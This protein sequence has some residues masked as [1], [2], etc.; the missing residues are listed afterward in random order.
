MKTLSAWLLA[1]PL[2]IL[3]VRADAL[4]AIGGITT[5]ASLPSASASTNLVYEI[6]DFTI[7][8]FVVSDGTT[9]E[10]LN[11]E[12]ELYS[13]GAAATTVT[14]TVTETNIKALLIPA[15]LTSANDSV[16]VETAWTY[17][18][19]N[20]TKTFVIR[21]SASS[22]DVSGGTAF[23]AS[24]SGSTGGSAQINTIIR[25]TNSVSAQYGY[26]N[27]TSTSYGASGSTAST[28]AI[29]TASAWY[30]NINTI[31]AG[32]GDTNILKG[33]KVTWRRGGASG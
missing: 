12:T 10:P 24:G 20:G 16:I 1:I 33:Y 29:N 31:V 14:G 6:T 21:G 5:F 4:Y 8:V 32:S 17:T 18:G 30:V 19:T 7:P 15:G 27:S 9:W 3:P 23:Q 2:L 28:G 11:G 13:S 22:G 25:N 26:A